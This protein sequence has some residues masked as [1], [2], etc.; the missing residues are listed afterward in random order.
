M[1][2]TLAA[3]KTYFEAE[4]DTMLATIGTE[5]GAS[6]PT[7]ASIDTARLKDRQ[8]PA[9]ELLPGT[10]EYS[11]ADEDAPFLQPIELHPV[12]VRVSQVGSEYKSVQEDLL[13]YVEAIRRIT[14]AD[15][16]YDDAFNWVRLVNANFAAAVDAQERGKLLQWVD[17]GLQAR[18]IRG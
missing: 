10:I 2:D 18:V 4:L 5:R 15:D 17:V 13:R 1:E 11:Y 16:T 14:I 9:I 3:V 8:Y 6:V 7:V 12:T